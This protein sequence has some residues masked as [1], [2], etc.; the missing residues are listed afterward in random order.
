MEEAKQNPLKRI[1]MDA[2][3]F[4]ANGKEYFIEGSMTIERYAQFQ[5][6]E[7]ELAY[8]FST[9]GIYEELKQI[10]KLMD[11]LMFTDCAVKLNNLTRGVAK[12]EEREP[13]V[14]KICA[15]YC[16][17][18]D[19]DRTIINEDM[20]SKKIQDWKAEGIDIRD[21]FALA[22]NSVNGLLEI[23]RSVTQSISEKAV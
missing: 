2:G 21:F 8:G 13:V 23:Y 9:K 19:E 22:F 6:Y 17:T 4:T 15:L 10:L 16:N 11:K 5:I 18:Q 20:I 3:K 12:I 14:L 7:K 1:D